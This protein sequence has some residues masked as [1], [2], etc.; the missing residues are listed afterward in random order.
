MKAVIEKSVISKAVISPRP[1]RDRRAWITGLGIVCAAGAGK[2]AFASALKKGRSGIR[3]LDRFS[4]DSFFSSW[5]GQ[6]PDPPRD[7]PRASRA[8]LLALQAA[9][10][11]IAQSGLQADELADAAVIFGVGAGAGAE[12]APTDDRQ[13]WPLGSMLVRHQPMSVVDLIG[14]RIGAQGRRLALMTACSS[15]GGAMASALDMIRLGSAELVIVG[16]A[17]ALTTLTFGGF[18]ALRAMDPEPCRPFHRDRAGLTLGEGAAVMIVELAERARARGARALAEL[19]GVGGA[20][21]AHHLT[22]PPA[23]G[24]GARAAM[25]AALGDAGIEASEVDYV[26]AHGT[27]TP[28]NDL[29]E[30]AALRA[31]FNQRRPKVSSTKAITGHALGAAS[32]LEAGACLLAMENGWLPGTVGLDQPDPGCVTGIDLLAPPGLPSTI[33]VALSNSFA[34]G[35]NNITV[36]LRRV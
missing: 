4:A 14:E 6:A 35:G 29:A 12:A 15:S 30:C 17:E 11:A 22:A 10:E 28:L 26:N 23:D 16:G 2:S 5:A 25:Q 33:D 8:D 13:R 36:V 1:P 32:A 19:A 31:V 20:A 9:R 7:D 24:R 27:A 18:S 3:E 21:D 34:F